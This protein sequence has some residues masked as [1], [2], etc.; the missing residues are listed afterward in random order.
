VNGWL[1]DTNVISELA[2]AGGDPK[3]AEWADSQD[4]D[5]LYISILTLGEYDKGVNNLP[6]EAPARPRIEASVVALAARFT[7][8]I[9]SLDDMVVRRWGR[10]SGT[11][12]RAT[13]QAPPVIDTLLAATAIEHHLYLATRNVRDVSLSGAAVFDPW[14]DDP[15]AFPLT[16]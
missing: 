14:S 1:L 11:V 12:Q 10:I 8:R 2:R 15:V 7:G 16:G 6:P 9:L 4:E 5:R 13:G 3:V